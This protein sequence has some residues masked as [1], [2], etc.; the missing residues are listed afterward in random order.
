M[1][2]ILWNGYD[3]FCIFTSTWRCDATNLS[4]YTTHIGNICPI[5]QLKKNG[6]I[7]TVFRCIF[8]QINLSFIPY[9]EFIFF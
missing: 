6:V 1:N 5:Y 7:K 8:F 3:L 9:F 2:S 4:I